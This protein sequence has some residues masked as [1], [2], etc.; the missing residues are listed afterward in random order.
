MAIP[1]SITEQ[2]VDVKDLEL[3]YR[4]LHNNATIYDINNNTKI[5]LPFESVVNKYKDILTDIVAIINLDDRLARHYLFKPKMLS[6]DLYGTV[7]LWSE[8]LRLNNWSSIS[9]FK[10]VRIKIYDPAR[11]KSY[12]NEILILEEKI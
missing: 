9:E 12:L 7:E 10:P 11:F 4:M 6:Y 5:N 3:S 8:L 2:I 1:S